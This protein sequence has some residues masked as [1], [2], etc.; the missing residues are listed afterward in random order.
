M[1][2][3]YKKTILKLCFIY[4]ALTRT[5]TIFRRKGNNPNKMHI[6]EIGNVQSNG[7]PNSQDH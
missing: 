5:C 4:V 2:S 7:W 3:N 6:L 1:S